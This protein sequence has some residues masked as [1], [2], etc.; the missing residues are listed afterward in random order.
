MN[1]FR[2]D[3]H[4]IQSY[5]SDK[6]LIVECFLRGIE[7]GPE[8]NAIRIESVSLDR[9]NHAYPDDAQD[10]GWLSDPLVL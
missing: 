1:K 8:D 10:G 3:F 5:E 9:T 2:L 4:G 7:C 6:Q